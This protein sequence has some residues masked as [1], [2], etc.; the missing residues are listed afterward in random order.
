MYFLVMLELP[1]VHTAASWKLS[2]SLS[3]FLGS[4]SSSLFCWGFFFLF[5]H[6][7][8]NES[9]TTKE[10]S[11]SGKAHG[12]LAHQRNAE[13]SYCEVGSGEVFNCFPAGGWPAGGSVEHKKVSKR[14]QLSAASHARVRAAGAAVGIT[15]LEGQHPRRLTQIS[16]SLLVTSP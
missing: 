5:L 14:P 10:T 16:V 8:V 15:T 6:A 11:R 1:L 4:H 7:A 3:L 9:L 13:G 12:G 2:L